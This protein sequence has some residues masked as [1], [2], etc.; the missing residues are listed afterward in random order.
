MTE[1]RKRHLPD[2][3]IGPTWGELLRAGFREPTLQ[4]RIDALEAE[5]ADLRLKY[6]ILLE[7]RDH[8]MTA[9]HTS[10]AGGEC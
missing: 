4:K 8:W 2:T 5:L 9:A 1:E 6:A 3:P 10:Q 7:S